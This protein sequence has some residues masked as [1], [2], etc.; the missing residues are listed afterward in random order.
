MAGTKEWRLFRL[1]VGNWLV[2]DDILDDMVQ[3]AVQA[4]HTVA[5]G[6]LRFTSGLSPNFS[7]WQVPHKLHHTPH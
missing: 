6:E 5:Q 1:Y 4:M 7:Y 2:S 3:T